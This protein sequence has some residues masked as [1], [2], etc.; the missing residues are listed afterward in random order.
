MPNVDFATASEA[1]FIIERPFLLNTLTCCLPSRLSSPEKENDDLTIA[2]SPLPRRIS[3]VH[4]GNSHAGMMTPSILHPYSGALHERR[5][6]RIVIPAN[7]SRR[8]SYPY[9]VLRPQDLVSVKYKAIVRS[10]SLPCQ[11]LSDST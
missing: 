11:L 1:L 8:L 6:R 2:R 5:S 10:T 4:V 9:Y 7:T 3:V